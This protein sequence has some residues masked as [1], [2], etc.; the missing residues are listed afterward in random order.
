M[1]VKKS[2][3][4]F[5]KE[6]MEHVDKYGGVT[7]KY[8]GIIKRTGFAV[9]NWDKKSALFVAEKE[10]SLKV[11]VNFFHEHEWHFIQCR[12]YFGIWKNAGE[13]VLTSTLVFNNENEALDFAASIRQDYIYDLGKQKLIEVSKNLPGIEFQEKS[14]A[15]SY[16]LINE[17]RD[18]KNMNFEDWE[19]S[20]MALISVLWEK[21]C[22]FLEPDLKYTKWANYKTVEIKFYYK[23]GPLQ[24]QGEGILNTS[25]PGHTDEEYFVRC[26]EGKAYYTEGTIKSEGFYQTAGLLFG[27]YYYKTGELKF[28]GKYNDK[29]HGHGGYYGPSHPVC[30]RYYS[31]TGKLLYEGEFDY[32]SSGVGWRTIIKPKGFGM[33]Y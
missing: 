21:Y 12:K 24:Y 22:S 1:P 32:S 16:K 17:A 7:A 28:E 18:K 19:K 26:G 9:A 30:G 13:I 5:A 4:D 31:K 25:L 3:I 20:R 27:R 23:S 2:E 8:C 29:V 11:L 6:I 10:W 14:K 33:Y 15:D